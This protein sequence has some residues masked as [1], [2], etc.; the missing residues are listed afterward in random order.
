MALAGST[1]GASYNTLGQSAVSYAV[2]VW[3]VN[4]S[5]TQWKNIQICQ[6]AALR[7]GTPRVT[8]GP[9]A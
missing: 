4:T 7:Q 1:W 5:S 6:N 2:P 9:S 8:V 3:S